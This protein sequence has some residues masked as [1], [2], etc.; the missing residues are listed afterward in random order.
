MTDKLGAEVLE[1][2]GAGVRILANYGV[3]YSHIC[4]G[5]R[6]KTWG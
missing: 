4:E 1:Q 5:F 3:G 2:P 6:A